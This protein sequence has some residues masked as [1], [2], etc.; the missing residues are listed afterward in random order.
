[1]R[2]VYLGL[3]NKFLQIHGALAQ[4]GIQT[5]VLYKIYLYYIT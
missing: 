3:K 4:K 2:G 5:F 1:M